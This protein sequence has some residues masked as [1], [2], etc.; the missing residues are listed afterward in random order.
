[1]PRTVSERI[2]ETFFT[3]LAQ[4]ESVGPETITELRSLYSKRQL[5]DARQLARWVQRMEER[6]AQ[7]QDADR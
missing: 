6:H 3:R 5:A 7:D 2:Y 4:L 1:M